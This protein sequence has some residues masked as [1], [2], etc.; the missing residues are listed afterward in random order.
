MRLIGLTGAAGSGKDAAADYLVAQHAWRKVSFAQP[1]KD[2]LCA[3]FGWSP[4]EMNDREW[5]ERMLP[6]IGKSPRQLMQ[7]IGTEWGREMV[8]PDLWLILAR[9]RITNHINC[10]ADVVVSDVRFDNE[11]EMIRGMGGT[12]V[13]ISRASIA[14]VSAHVSEVG[15]A[16][17]P[18]DIR[19]SNNGDIASLYAAMNCLI[20]AIS[21][22]AVGEL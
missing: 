18:A 19:L 13:H 6:D 3:M 9:D 14:S 20:P 11:A 12:I 10:G 8:R 15:V 7:T 17:L 4:D 16:I 22:N 1:L 5:K 2:G 21:L